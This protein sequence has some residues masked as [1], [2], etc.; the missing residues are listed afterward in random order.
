[1]IKSKIKIFLFVL[2]ASTTLACGTQKKMVDNAQNTA[3][4][5]DFSPQKY[6]KT[7]SNNECKSKWIAAKIKCTI[8]MGD[9]DISTKGELRMKE[10]EVIQ[11]IL[12]DPLA[13][14]IEVGRLEFGKQ[15]FKMLDRVNKRYIDMPYSEIEFLKKSNINFNTLQNLFR[16]HVF[17]PAKIKPA[18]EDFTY[19]N[20]NGGKPSLQE[21]VILQYADDILEYKF[22][23]DPRTE[24]LNKTLITGKK[25]RESVFEFSYSD[26][27]KFE[28]KPFPHDMAM[29]FIM[30]EQK[31]SIMFKINSIK[32]KDG[33]T[34][35][36]N[37]P[38]R[39]APID[40]E[41]LF[42]SLIEK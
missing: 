38:S 40:P 1:M 24:T 5:G 17:V 18:P 30:G 14:I 41:K 10:D 12:N 28:G 3:I 32:D 39:Y 35:N 33:W 27:Q 36:T 21:N 9:Q 16:N 25:D 26:F 15:N 8:A 11:I 20:E 6:L 7:L 29:S 23:T 37:I 19:S 31:A 34:T 2:I 4:Y 42:K 13:A 22:I